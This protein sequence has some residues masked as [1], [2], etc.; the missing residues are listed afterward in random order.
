MFR[1]VEAHAKGFKKIYG[2]KKLKIEKFQ[3]GI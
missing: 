1:K 2:E 3:L